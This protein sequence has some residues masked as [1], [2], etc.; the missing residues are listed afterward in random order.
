M[1]KI[2]SLGNCLLCKKTAVSWMTKE[3]YI[4][5]WLGEVLCHLQRFQ[6]SDASPGSNLVPTKVRAA[7]QGPLQLCLVPGLRMCGVVCAVP[8][9]PSIPSLCGEDIETWRELYLI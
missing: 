4:N 2:L 9:H 3:S 1:L 7:G 6:T 5:L 8:P